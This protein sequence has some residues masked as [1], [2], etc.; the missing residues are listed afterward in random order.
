MSLQ[1]RLEN[2]LIAQCLIGN[3]RYGFFFFL[4]LTQLSPENVSLKFPLIVLARGKE[5][6]GKEKF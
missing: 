3:R 2:L 4:F 1:E 6:E 5:P